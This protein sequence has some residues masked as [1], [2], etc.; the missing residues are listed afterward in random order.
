MVRIALTVVRSPIRARRAIGLA[1]SRGTRVVCRLGLHRPRML[2]LHQMVQQDC[3]E[4]C[5]Q[6]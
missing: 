1:G 3:V 4:G 6:C 2:P 5:T